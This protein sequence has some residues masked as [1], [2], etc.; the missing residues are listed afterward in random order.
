[1]DLP[2]ALKLLPTPQARDGKGAPT[3]GYNEGN[4]PREAQD[5]LAFGWGTYEPA[6]RRWEA[7]TRPAPAPVE[8]ARNDKVRHTIAFAEW[9][10]G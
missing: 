2:S 8:P 4:L 3:L 5:V 1:M 10:M 9:M 6:V 7:L